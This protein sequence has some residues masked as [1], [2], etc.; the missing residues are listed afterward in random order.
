MQLP[1]EINTANI[2]GSKEFKKEIH[3]EL[4]VSPLAV[5]VYGDSIIELPEEVSPMSEKFQDSYHYKFFNSSMLDTQLVIDF[6]QPD[7]SPHILGI[8]QVIDYE[9]PPKLSNTLPSILDI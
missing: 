2:I 4:V 5:E 7:S 9:Q 8:Q 1:K 3:E 6:E